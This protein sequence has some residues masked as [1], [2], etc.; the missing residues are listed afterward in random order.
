MV[1]LH[2][3]LL[4]GLDDGPKDLETSVAMARMA[5]GDG[6]THVVATPH[7][8]GRYPFDP[9]ANAERLA[10]LQ[11]AIAAESIDLTVATGCDFHVSYDNVLDAIA[12]PHKYTL[13]GTDYLLVELSD[14]IIPP[15][16]GET[17]YELRLAGMVP[18]LTHPE[19]NP[20]LQKDSTRLADW[21]RNE[22][23]V[24]ITAGSVLGRMGKSAERMAHTLLANRWV[25]FIASDAHNLTSRP[26]LM[27]EACDLIAKRYGAEYA[28]LLC[29]VNPQAVF[30][31][32]PL[33]E[34]EPPLR[35]YDDD[36]YP[37]APWWKR[38]KQFFGGPQAP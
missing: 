34:Q 2:H 1:D 33:P 38:W 12:H 36:E 37:D 6:I 29:T 18:I 20:L 27:R 11:Q 26:P 21:L 19:R 17:F 7:A 10:A 24:Q 9:A 16:V 13:N 5:A 3:H 30:N 4:P 31:G 23:L 25:H 28:N 15:H 22:M 32:L 8:S 35:L 14:L